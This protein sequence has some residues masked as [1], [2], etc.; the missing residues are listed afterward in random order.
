MAIKYVPYFPDPVSGQA[1]LDNFVRTQRIL[2][3]RE[4]DKVTE[5]IVRGMPL[6]EVTDIERVGEVESD[7]MIIH[8]ECVSACAYLKE[9]GIKVDLVYID[10]PFASGADYAKKVYIRRNPLV[11]KAIKQAQQELDD[12]ELKA[13]EE[14]MYGDIWDKE[15]YLNWMYENLMAI[16]SVMSENASIY[17]HL[18]Y[19]IGHYVKILLDEIFGE[20]NFR[21]EIIWK[22]ATA[23]S[24]AEFY[25]NN[26]D[27]IYFYTKSQIDYNFN[28]IFQPYDESYLA[29]FTQVDKDGRKWESGNLT[30]KGLSGGGY[31]YTYKGCRSLWR[32]PL[33]TMEKMDRDGRLH[34]TKNGGIR[35]LDELPG[36]PSQSMW[37][38]IKPINSQAKE[39]E[40]YATQKPEA[41]LER[42]IKA[43]S[44]EGMIVA[45]FFGGS[46]VTSAVAAKSG[47]NF[48]HADVNINSIQTARDRLKTSGASFTV[49]KVQD[50]VTLY[51]NPIQTKDAITRII[52]GLRVDASIGSMWIGSIG[53]STYGSSPVYIPDLMD[54]SSRVLDIVTLNR[55]INDAMPQLP[56]TTKRVIVYYIDMVDRQE[57]DTFIKD[58]NDTVIE[59]ELRDLKELLDNA[60]LQDEVEYTLLE[61]TT[62]MVDIFTVAIRRFYSD[63]VSHKINDFNQKA[64]AN[65]KKKFTPIEISLEGLEAIEM[66]SLDCTNAELNA[67]WHSDSEIKIEKDSTVTINGRKTS[68]FWDG[69]IHSDTKPLRLKIRNIC[70][71]ETIIVLTE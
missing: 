48:I 7:N 71:D 23:H 36:M 40:G 42:I 61:D 68:D 51:R 9:K 19:H 28:T 49:K 50:G 34:F 62:K 6:Y 46:G 66:I 60:I 56:P 35:S 65:S 30:A 8:G 41:L 70:G 58:N 4:S 15:K 20:D 12:D 38:D 3:Y 16:R 1:V 59:V 69:T 31:D 11:A 53:D 14:K 33:E 47:R 27:C 37:L 52:P 13:F 45:D 55:I 43:S 5:R 24:D 54:S 57:L 26:F 22:R 18:D 67:P 32:M 10:P 63:R 21:N 44:N 2:R 29:R 39:K 25:G 17:V 64:M